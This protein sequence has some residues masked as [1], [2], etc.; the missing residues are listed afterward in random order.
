M[1]IIISINNHKGGVAKTV[2]SCNLSHALARSGKKVLLIDMDPQ[3]NATSLIIGKSNGL[4]RENSVYEVLDTEENFSVA[5]CI[6]TTQYERLS[7]IPNIHDTATHEPRLLLKIPESFSILKQK[8]KAG[9]ITAKYDF[10]IIDNPPSLGILTINSLTAA[11]FSI[12]PVMAGSRHSIEGLVQVI[13]LIE[14]IKERSN[15]DLMFLR[16]LVTMLDRRNGEHNSTLSHIREIFPRDRVFDTF[17]RFSSSFQK[18]ERLSMTIFK[19]KS[20]VP[21]AIDYKNLA[22]EL[23]KIVEV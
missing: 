6:T 22:D 18:A 23:I 12:V 21:G 3:C 8:L 15:P 13:K 2:T 16:V 4:T 5:D 19:H 9:E 11:N 20:S 14:E 17:I 10:V 7:I 1:G